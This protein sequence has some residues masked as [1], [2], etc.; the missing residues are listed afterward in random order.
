MV[1]LAGQPAP[2]AQGPGHR[3]ASG[4]ADREEGGRDRGR[5]GG[6]RRGREAGRQQRRLVAQIARVTLPGRFFGVSASAG[7]RHAR[8]V[9]GRDARAIATS[10]RPRARSRSASAIWRWR[11]RS[12]SSPKCSSAR[13]ATPPTSS[14]RRCT[15][16]PTAAARRITLRPEDT[17][18]IARAFISDGLAQHLPL[19]YF[20]SG[21]M[22]RYERP[23]KGRHA[24]VPPDRRRAARRR[25]AAGRRRDH[26]GRRRDPAP[27]RRA[28]TAA[29]LEINTLGDTESR[30]AYREVLVDYLSGHQATSCR[31]DSLRPA[32]A[33]S[34]AHPRFQGRGRQGDRRQRA[35]LFRL[36]ERRRAAISSPR[37]LDGLD[38]IGIAYAVNPRLVRG[39]DY[40]CHTCFEFITDDLGAQGTVHGRRP[41]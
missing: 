5:E 25:R 33:Q 4:R 14:P 37:V 29:M 12:S 10:S 15:P 28:G 41:L 32:G 35:G 2:S 1:Y 16:S 19:K 3:R 39:L 24:P 22:F 20:Y 30:Q 34:A 31:K 17:A 38:A 26:R 23:Q 11:R 9:A 6:R 8:P 27:P 40:Y 21:P 36:S 18:S 13:S 7:S